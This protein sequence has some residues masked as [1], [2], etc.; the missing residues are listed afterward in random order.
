MLPVRKCTSM[1]MGERRCGSF[2]A[3]SRVE[4]K[5]FT[6]VKKDL[7]P[8]RNLS[9]PSPLAAKA[10]L[11]EAKALAETGSAA[12]AIALLR[13]RYDEIPQPAGDLTLAQCY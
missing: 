5:D 6:Q 10:A 2:M 9:A 1:P 12:A 7:A 11:L 13:E 8:F 4:L 3:A